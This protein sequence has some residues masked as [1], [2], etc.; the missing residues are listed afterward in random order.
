M[1]IQNVAKF[2]IKNKRKDNNNNIV[3]NE[4]KWRHIYEYNE[5]SNNTEVNYEK[6]LPWMTLYKSQNDLLQIRMVTTIGYVE[7]ADTDPSGVVTYNDNY[8]ARF[9]KGFPLLLQSPDINS[10][11][12]TDWE[13]NWPFY[14]HEAGVDFSGNLQTSYN[15]NSWLGEAGAGTAN[16]TNSK[17]VTGMR[18]VRNL[19]TIYLNDSHFLFKN[20]ANRVIQ[21]VDNGVKN[22]PN[23]TNPEYLVIRLDDAVEES[24]FSYDGTNS[25]KGLYTDNSNYWQSSSDDDQKPKLKIFNYVYYGYVISP[26]SFMSAFTTDFLRGIA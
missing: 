5:N 1:S 22:Y 10:H 7:K 14:I 8:E 17:V 9:I 23:T 3:I 25:T 4:N 2:T 19:L 13:H 18:N 15:G 6:Q 24:T 12:A 11:L 20:T 21:Y 16:A 26:Y